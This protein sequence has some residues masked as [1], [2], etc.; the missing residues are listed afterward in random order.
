MD[1]PRCGVAG[2]APPRAGDE[3][4]GTGSAGG[5]VRRA[6]LE[7]EARRSHEIGDFFPQRMMMGEGNPIR[8]AHKTAQMLTF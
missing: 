4:K 1:H 5:G 7:G 2:G 8:E 6:T 3:G